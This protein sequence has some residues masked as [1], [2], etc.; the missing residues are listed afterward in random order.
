V[1]ARVADERDR[2]ASRREFLRTM[3]GKARA[4]AAAPEA[5]IPGAPLG[6]NVPPPVA[7]SDARL[8]V[9]RRA[10]YGP[11]ASDVDEVKRVGYQRWLNDQVNFERIDNARTR[12]MSPRAGPI[13]R[14]DRRS[15]PRSMRGRCR[16]NCRWR[17]S[18]APRSR[19]GSCTSAW[20]SS[21]PIISA[22]TSTRSA[23]SSWSTT[24]TS[25]VAT[26][27]GSSA[28]WCGRARRARPCSPI[29]IRT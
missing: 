25:F 7:W 23:I 13:W 24:A 9:V 14:S 19:V 8:R 28:I 3:T 2:A 11:R 22:S 15:S 27:W 16:T 26:R 5:S 6:A 1:Q 12:P 18:T 4:E 29:S 10:G 21:G 20:W 17:R